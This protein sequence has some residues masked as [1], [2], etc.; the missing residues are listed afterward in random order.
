MVSSALD[1]GLISF[2]TMPVPIP[3][4]AAPAS[5]AASRPRR[6][7]G[8]RDRLLMLHELR[9]LLR[10]AGPIIV[11]QLGGVAMNTTD[12]IMVAPLGVVPLAAAGLGS[13]VQSFLMLVFTGVVMGSTPLVAQA[14]GAGDHAECRRVVAQAH[15]VALVLAVPF[16]AIL[17]FG[18]SVTLA[19]GQPPEVAVLAGEYMRA[20]AWGAWPVLA[21]MAFRQYLE[22][23]GITT[24]AMVI[25]FMALAI[26]IVGNRALIYGVEGWVAPMGVAGSAWA[27]T[28][29]RWAML[30][31]M[32]GYL[33]A[34]T[35]LNPF[36]GVSWRPAAARLRRVVSVGLPIGVQ[37]GAEVGIFAF[38]AV[39][40]GW[41]G[42]EAQAAHQVTINLAATTFMVALGVAIAGSIR[43]GHHVGAGSR[44][45]VRRA[46]V[47]TYA[48]SLGFMGLCALLFLAAPRAL[49][50]LYTRDPQIVEVGVAL[51]FMGAL[52]QLFDGAQVAGL[53]VLRGAADTRVPMLI[54]LV[55]YWAV[56]FPVAY[57]LGFRT[58]MGPTGIWAG[59][60]ASLAVV[61][62]M[63][64]FRVRRVLWTP[65]PARAPAH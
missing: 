27:T 25:T 15:W 62:V 59:L 61:A 29:V 49:I 34:H 51:L 56:G 39:M 37:N 42:A 46:T 33:L 64:V 13:A 11:S 16:A 41:I 35:G 60:V 20:L 22:G 50:G 26:N 43:V 7:R 31:A 36:R 52:F 32:T 21:F 44:R 12:T 57:V 4:L 3:P 6:P 58:A 24:P 48:L 18:E 19:L 65:P 10:I 2:A 63:L 53:A 14:F 28:L 40:M 38:A 55:G 1:A 54:T 30:L 45:G 23:M 47:A 8:F 5:P 9:A 17:F